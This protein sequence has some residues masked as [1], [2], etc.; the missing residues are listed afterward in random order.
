MTVSHIEPAAGLRPTPGTLVLSRVLL[1]LMRRSLTLF[2]SLLLLSGCGAKL[3][4]SQHPTPE[5]L[6]EASMKAYR[7]GRWNA[8]RQGFQRLTFELPP[9]DDRSA[10]VRYYLAECMLQQGERLEAARQF[11]RVADEY[12]RHRL[13]PDALLRAGDAYLKLWSNPELDPAYGETALATYTELLG[14]FPSS[15]AAPRAQLRVA[16]LNERFAAKDFR[17]GDFYLRF[18]AY[19]SAIIYFK[20]IIARYPRTSY[21]PKAV[22]GLVKAYDRIGYD[23]EKHEMCLHLEQYYPGTEDG[24]GRCQG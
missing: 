7:S 15:P 20:D 19:D 6:Y 5:S 14:R 13:A 1:H 10:D 4:P 17:N 9:R 24:E 12:P 11:R 8:A 2:V 3:D 22:L 21:A 16:Q 23:E 18:R